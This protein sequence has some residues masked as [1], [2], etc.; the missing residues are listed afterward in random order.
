MV[1]VYVLL[2]LWGKGMIH[3]PTGQLE[4]TC[5]RMVTLDL[6]VQTSSWVWEVGGV[7]P[8]HTNQAF[9]HC[10]HVQWEVCGG[11]RRKR[12][13]LWIRKRPPCIWIRKTPFVE[14]HR[15]DGHWD[16][17]VVYCQQSAF[18]TCIRICNNLSIPHLLGG[19]WDGQWTKISA[20]FFRGWSPKS[21]QSQSLGAKLKKLT[22]QEIWH[23]ECWSPSSLL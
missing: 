2:W 9:L 4:E 5:E 12:I 23:Q 3:L 7:L 17:T 21:C 15:S 22:L 6:I 13:L 11:V 19:I 14:H 18:S 16:P 8:T 1:T 10:S 20:S